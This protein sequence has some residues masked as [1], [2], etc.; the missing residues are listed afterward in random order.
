MGQTLKDPLPDGRR[1]K[2]VG[3]ARTFR[4]SGSQ[5][6]RNDVCFFFCRAG[7]PKPNLTGGANAA[8][9]VLLQDADSYFILSHKFST[10]LGKVSRWTELECFCFQRLA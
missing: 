1:R 10:G 4:Q 2:S 7:K 6:Y 3:Q 5:E 8:F 9:L